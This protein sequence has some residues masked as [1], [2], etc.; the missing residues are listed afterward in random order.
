MKKIYF[1]AVLFIT[2]NTISCT[3]SNKDVA[4]DDG[5]FAKEEA[6]AKPY[7]ADNFPVDDKMFGKGR[8]NRPV[9][10]P[11]LRSENTAWFT[12][13]SLK[14]TL[15]FILSSDNDRLY[16]AGFD[17]KNLPDEFILRND[18]CDENKYRASDEHSLQYFSEFFTKAK[19]ID[20][21]YFTSNMGFKMG[22]AKEKAINR[23]GKPDSIKTANGFEKYYWNPVA[24]QVTK[25]HVPEK[26]LI[27]IDE[28]K[29]FIEMYFK[30]NK[31][32]VL[33]FDNGTRYPNE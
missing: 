5:Q 12:N 27:L 20:S 9:I 22:D 3:Q 33:I 1:A 17:N 8:A 14:Q 11:H 28:K 26:D 31:L 7:V 24:A 29:Q 30:N 23:Y 10:T 2:F 18:L 25:Q 4:I 19:Q 15:M 16:T 13:D 6:L 32:V 21:K